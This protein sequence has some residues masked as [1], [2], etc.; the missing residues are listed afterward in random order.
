MTNSVE[1]PKM[2]RQTGTNNDK[3]CGMSK[4]D[5]TNKYKQTQIKINNVKHPEMTGQTNTN[6]DKQCKTSRN[7]KETKKIEINTN[8]E[9]QWGNL[10]NGKTAHKTN[11]HK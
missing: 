3:Q 7:V 6:K 1:H 10:K 8:K 9:K 2:I 5:E 4:N 11:K